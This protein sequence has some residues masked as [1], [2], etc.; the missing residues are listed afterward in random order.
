MPR[1]PIIPPIA[2]QPEPRLP[3]ALGILIALGMSS[4]MWA[5]IV[6]LFALV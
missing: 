4:L 1:R 2:S 6:A 3:L 5:V